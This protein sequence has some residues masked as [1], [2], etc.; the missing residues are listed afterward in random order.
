MMAS[1]SIETIHTVAGLRARVRE[2]RAAGERVALVPTMGALH[3]GHVALMTAARRDAD[4]IIVTIFVN[5]TQFG[6]TEDLS[7]YPRTLDFRRPRKV[8]KEL[9]RPWFQF[10]NPRNIY[11]WFQRTTPGPAQT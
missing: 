9:V 2:W 5:P 11:Q 8:A 10:H 6:P 7:R 3:V 4:R 1:Q